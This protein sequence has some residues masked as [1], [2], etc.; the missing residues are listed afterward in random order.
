LG[1]GVAVGL[2]GLVVGE[3]MVRDGRE[4]EKR[5]YLFGVEKG[6]LERERERCRENCGLDYSVRIKIIYLI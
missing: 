4:K 6:F 5:G 3:K 1:I 2:V